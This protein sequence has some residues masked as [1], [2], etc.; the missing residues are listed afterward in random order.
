MDPLEKAAQVPQF[1][2]PFEGDL[3]NKLDGK[4]GPGFNIHKP[5]LH[6]PVMVIY[7]SHMVGRLLSFLTHIY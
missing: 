3:T 5:M 7:F 2:R 6:L 1:Y 4:Y